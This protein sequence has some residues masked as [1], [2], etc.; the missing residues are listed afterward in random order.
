[1]RGRESRREGGGG[2]IWE[3]VRVRKRNACTVVAEKA[4]KLNKVY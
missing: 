4:L 2:G 3:G 1:M